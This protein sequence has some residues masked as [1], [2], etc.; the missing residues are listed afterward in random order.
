FAIH[1][2]ALP[3][4]GRGTLELALLPVT[5]NPSDGPPRLTFTL[6]E[7]AVVRLSVI[8][9]TGRE[10]ATLGGEVRAAGRH[11]LPGDPGAAGGRRHGARGHLLRPA[12][13]R[14]RAARPSLRPIPVGGAFALWFAGATRETPDSS[15]RASPPLVCW[16][17]ARDSGTRAAFALWFAGATRETR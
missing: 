17:Y 5:P 6:S 7:P 12:R 2:G 1:G 9:V 15:S 14:P 4:L 13:G 16:R 11:E 3:V 8:D 10:V